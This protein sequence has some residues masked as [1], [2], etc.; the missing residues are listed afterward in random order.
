MLRVERDQILAFRLASHHLNARLPAGSLAAAGL[1]VPELLDALARAA[2]EALDGRPLLIDELRTEIARRMPALTA[3][4]V[5][6]ALT[7]TCPSRC[8]APLA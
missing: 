5:R 3:W 6:A 7:P 1:S 8:S 4:R 2:T